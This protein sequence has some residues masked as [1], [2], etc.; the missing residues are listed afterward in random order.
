MEHSGPTLQPGQ[1]FKSEATV[2]WNSKPDISHLRPDVAKGKIM[3]DYAFP[4]AGVY[5]VKAI[6]SIPDA[7]S[8]AV[9][10]KI[11]SEPIEIVVNEPV[12]DDLKVWNQ[13]KDS[14]DIA[15][16]IQ[17]GSFLTSQNE[18]E[19]NMAEQVKQI[20]QNYR[21]SFLSGQMQQKLENF[22]TNEQRKKETL[23]KF[24]VKPKN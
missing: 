6:A 22:K 13:I 12:G 1:S 20:T 2:L 4:K 24:G 5:L 16:F 10:A 17:T 8:D 3:T 14:G 21:N 18:V 23:Y 7:N 15:F 19:K 9:S 11:E